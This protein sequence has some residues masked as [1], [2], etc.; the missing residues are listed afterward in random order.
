MGIGEWKFKINK[1]GKKGGG[2][3]IGF[4]SI[5][6]SKT[7]FV[8]FYGTNGGNG[9][10]QNGTVFGSKNVDKCREGDIFCIYLDLLEFNVRYRINN[11]EI[12][13]LQNINPRRGSENESFKMAVS[14]N[15]ISDSI[16]MVSHSMKDSWKRFKDQK[17]RKRKAMSSDDDDD[18]LP[19]KKRRF[20]RNRNKN[21]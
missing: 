10:V 8:Y 12:K 18:E 11:G 9:T 16:S 7:G 1:L 3:D 17:S 20:D 6:K 13:M 21:K 15:G 4:V 5:S 19:K 14:C 2:M